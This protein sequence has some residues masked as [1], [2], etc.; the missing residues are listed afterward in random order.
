MNFSNATVPVN[1]IGASLT[2]QQVWDGLVLKARD[3]RLFSSWGLH[4]GEDKILVQLVKPT[5]YPGV[6]SAG[7]PCLLT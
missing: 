3:A 6:K 5:V 2:Q 4:A 1:P 7:W